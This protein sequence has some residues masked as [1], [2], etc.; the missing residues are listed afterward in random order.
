M[1]WRVIDTQEEFEEIRHKVIQ[2]P[3]HCSKKANSS[4]DE[5]ADID[6]DSSRTW[7]IDKPNLPKTPKGFRK[8]LVLRKD[9]SKL[10]AYYITPTGKK[11]R[12]RNEIAAFLNTNPQYQG[13]SATDFDFSSPKIMQDTVPEI[14]QQKDSSTKKVKA[15]KNDV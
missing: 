13:I 12:T 14:F 2:D 6:Y 3:F 4:C 5:P 9:Y 1:K 8:S 11:M 7:V 15:S 10:D